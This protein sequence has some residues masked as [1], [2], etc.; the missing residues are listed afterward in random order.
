MYKVYLRKFMLE[1]LL[2]NPKVHLMYLRLER[3]LQ[4]CAFLSTKAAIWGAFI[5]LPE[6]YK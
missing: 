1:G 6:L 2:M 3:N 5:F 4:F